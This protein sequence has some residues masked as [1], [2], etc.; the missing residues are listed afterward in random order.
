M[1]RFYI[2][3][4]YH[5]LLLFVSERMSECGHVNL[6]VCVVVCGINGHNAFKQHI[7]IKHAHTH[8]GTAALTHTYTHTYAIANSHITYMHMR[9][10]NSNFACF[11]KRRW[12]FD[13]LLYVPLVYTY[14]HMYMC[15]MY[16]C[17][18]VYTCVY[19]AHDDVRYIPIHT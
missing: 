18:Y 14:V 3:H 6:C 17:M 8:T 9:V 1:W 19:I 5:T 16:A 13:N 15:S 11:K 12:A 7:I 4:R 2:G 10:Y